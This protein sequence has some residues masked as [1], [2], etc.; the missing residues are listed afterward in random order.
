[1][2]S[3][4]PG[5]SAAG[6]CAQRSRIGRRARAEDLVS[7]RFNPDRPDAVWCGDVTYL[8]TDQGWLFLATVIDLFSRRVIGWSVDDHLRTDLPAAAMR[9]A[10]TARRGTV[11]GVIFHSDRGC[12]YT[13]RAFGELCARHGVRQSM[14][15]VG[16]CWDN[17]PAESFFATLKRELVY[18]QRWA[19]K[20][21]ARRAVVRWIE[22]W[23]NRHRL[24]STLGYLTPLEKE[25]AWHADRR[26]A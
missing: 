16:V 14:G 17:S 10:V 9:M 2:T 26:A 5:S 6:G 20:A 22:G 8:R 19:T 7:R 11:D 1:M 3:A 13:A 23:Y 4:G 12:Q 24:H 18:R 21:D 15:A 25:N